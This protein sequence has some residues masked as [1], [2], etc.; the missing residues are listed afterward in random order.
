MA[1]LCFQPF[2]GGGVRDG[3]AGF[4]TNQELLV[5]NAVGVANVN[6][7]EWGGRGGGGGEIVRGDLLRSNGLVAECGASGFGAVVGDGGGGGGGGWWW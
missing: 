5:E 6:G 3:T 2:Q 4:L 7:G 1:E